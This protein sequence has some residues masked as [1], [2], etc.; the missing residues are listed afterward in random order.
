MLAASSRRH[1]SHTMAWWLV[2]EEG[3]IILDLPG[4]SFISYYLTF[5]LGPG[6]FISLRFSLRFLVVFVVCVR[7][8]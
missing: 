7:L 4:L 2:Q 1:R 8:L 5:R 3:A 6:L